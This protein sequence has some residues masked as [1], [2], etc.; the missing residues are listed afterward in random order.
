[1]EGTVNLATGYSEPHPLEQT[2]FLASKP[3]TSHRDKRNRLL[4]RR[5]DWS[6]AGHRSPDKHRHCERSEAIYGAASGSMDCFVAG[7]PRNDGSKAGV[8]PGNEG[9]RA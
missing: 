4:S 6:C 8:A 5:L 3:V 2:R 1:M 7:A 9:H